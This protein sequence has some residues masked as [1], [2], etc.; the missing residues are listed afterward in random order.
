V[1]SSS[2]RRGRRRRE[3]AEKKQRSTSKDA[4]VSPRLVGLCALDE[5]VR[6]SKDEVKPEH[7]HYSKDTEKRETDLLPVR[8][9]EK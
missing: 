4:L 7:V 1:K 3:E 8:L 5:L 2:R 6:D 9:H